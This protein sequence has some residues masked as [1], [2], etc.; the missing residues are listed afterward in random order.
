MM[1]PAFAHARMNVAFPRMLD[2]A[3]ALLQRMALLADGSEHDVEVEMTHVTADIIFRTI[4][5]VPMDGEDARRVFSSFARYQELAPRL[6]LPSLYGMRWLVWPWQRRQSTRAANE[7]RAL[8]GN[9]RSHNLIRRSCRM[10]YPGTN[11][12]WAAATVIGPLGPSITA[13]ITPRGSSG[14]CSTRG[15]RSPG[16]SSG[17]DSGAAG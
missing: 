10:L 1:D 12:R 17:S 13:A 5:S 16:T 9:C 4:F 11:D 2:A 3:E 14:T 15:P 8:L 6:M 7:I